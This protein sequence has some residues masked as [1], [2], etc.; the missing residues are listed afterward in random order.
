MSETYRCVKESMG[1]AFLCFVGNK[2]GYRPLPAQ[3]EQT[4]YDVLTQYLLKQGR[5]LSLMQEYYKLDEN[6]VPANYVLKQKTTDSKTWWEDTDV[7]QGQFREAA[8]A[9]FGDSDSRSDKYHVSVTETEITEGAFNNT[10][11]SQQVRFIRRELEGYLSELHLHRKLTDMKSDA[12]LDVYAKEKLKELK[13]DKMG[14]QC[15]PSVIY[16]VSYTENEI[17][18][19]SEYIRGVCDHVCE[20]LTQAI[21]NGY[22]S[23]LHVEDDNEFQES[24]HHRAHANEKASLFVGREKE[25]ERILDYIKGSDKRPLAVHG[26][27]GCG[28]TA[29]MA[30]AATKAKNVRRESAMILRFLGT[31]GR[32]GSARGLLLNICVQITRIYG[33][34]L[35][36][37]P[38]SYKDLIKH[39]QVCLSFAS[40]SKPLILFLDSLDQLSNEDFGQNLAWLSLADDLPEHVKLVVS[41]LPTRC[42][43]I[44]KANLTDANFV[45]VKA[46]NPDHGKD[47][48]TKMLHLHKRT[49]TQHQEK[50]VLDAFKNC[51]LPLF[52]RLV[53]DVAIKWHSYDDVDAD[54]IADDMQGLIN[55]LFL[56]LETRYGELFVRHTLA[57]ITAAK[58]GLSLAELE[59]V[60]SCD[61]E[62]LTSIFKWWTPPV[63]RIPPLLWARVRNE[64]GIYLAERGTDGISAYGWYHRQFW[65]TAE[66]R[67]LYTPPIGGS[68]TFFND[69]HGAIADYF[70][71]KWVNGKSYVPK[72]ETDTKIA[73]RKLP[74]QS[75]IVSGDRL[76]RR[77]LNKR[78]L[79]ELPFHLIQLK[80]WK[81]FQTLVMDLAYI[82]AKFEAQD[83]YNCLSELIEATKLSANEDIKHLTR[84]VGSNLGFL[85]REPV[86]VYQM[87]SQL[88]KANPVSGLL[89][90]VDPSYLPLPL[91]KNL[92][93][94]DFPDPCEMTMYGHTQTLRCCDYSPKGNG[95][96]FNN[97]YL[98]NKSVTKKQMNKCMAEVY[99]LDWI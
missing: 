95:K 97:T 17:A 4:E 12:T 5:D 48:M 19:C 75:L 13:E 37:I 61:D 39:F 91:M 77:Q 27:S 38:T 50:L 8:I 35:S 26:V 99:G 30:V 7:I 43:D 71:G 70:E 60:L 85:I 2:Y 80:D 42:L 86:A 82:E 20:E 63:R 93:D 23:K 11:Q 53:V 72:G 10:N 21:F 88:S 44:L 51:P 28:K 25:I 24:V 79:S 9:C 58:Q 34:D 33:Q 16:D 62:V 46:L 66:K 29:L 74:S 3:I 73:D 31:T 87:A 18:A 59:D 57:Y 56:R 76:S 15:S 67:Y 96:R 54:D 92:D 65:E 41:S 40:S 84:F 69:A 55:K 94:I 83:G 47:I 81:R 6:A 49:V 45:E 89:T 32:S 22:E 98:T 78:K 64:L 52:L 14:S 68:G 1:P 36:K 90:K